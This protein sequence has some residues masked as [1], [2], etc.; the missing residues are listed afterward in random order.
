M[1][2][3]FGAGSALF[4]VLDS[5][6]VYQ[7]RAVPTLKEVSV[8]FD[9]KIETQFGSAAY[10]EDAAAGEKKISGTIKWGAVGFEMMN[11]IIFAG[12]KT[13]GLPR[14]VIGEAGIPTTNVYT[15]VNT[16]GTA[17]DL[18]AISAVD[19]YPFTRVTAGVTAGQYI[20]DGAA[21]TYTFAAGDTRAAS[22]RVNYSWTDTTT[23]ATWELGNP[24][25]GSL[26][27]FELWLWKPRFA[28]SLGIRLYHCVLSGADLSSKGSAY[29][30]PTANFEAFVDQTL[31]SPGQVFSTESL[32]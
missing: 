20:F 2:Y 6:G 25:Q 5:A 27:D 13:T 29:T 19:G 9:G 22:V 14:V 10:P 24:I 12:T 31:N 23:G 21:G 30:D 1:I 18:G 7:A 17:T 28:K 16:T 26:A 15:I 4:R 8:K 32:D 3:V 11:K